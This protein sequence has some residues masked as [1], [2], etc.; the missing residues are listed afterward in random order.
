MELDYEWVLFCDFA[1]LVLYCCVATYGVTS[2]KYGKQVKIPLL[3]KEIFID[4]L[5]LTI[6]GSLCRRPNESEVLKYVICISKGQ[7]ISK[8]NFQA[9]DSPKK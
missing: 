1:T 3:I 8:A 2:L 7:L 6:D 4:P 9:V 5:S